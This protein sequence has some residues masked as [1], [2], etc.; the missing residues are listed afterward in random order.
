VNEE[1]VIFGI[2]LLHS[3]FWV[4]GLEFWVL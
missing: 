4:G 1:L 2:V 3:G